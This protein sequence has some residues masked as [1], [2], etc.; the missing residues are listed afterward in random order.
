MSESIENTAGVIQRYQLPELVELLIKDQKLHS[1]LFELNVEIQVAV[2]AVGQNGGPPVPGA[3]V[4]FKSVGLRAVERPHP[5]A[6]DAAVVNPK[7]AK[8]APTSKKTQP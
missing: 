2:G 5:L 1:G 3:I 6:V 4:G 8:K 7:A